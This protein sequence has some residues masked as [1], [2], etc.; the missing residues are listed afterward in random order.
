MARAL[1]DGR[2]PAS[3]G[4]RANG[5]GSSPATGTAAASARSSTTTH[6]ATGARCGAAGEAP[7][8]PDSKFASLSGTH[9][10]S[11]RRRIGMAASV[12]V[13]DLV[14]RRAVAAADMGEIA[15]TDRRLAVAAGDIQ[16]VARLAQAGKPA[17]ER[18]QQFLTLRDAGAPM[19][20]ARREI[21]VMQVVG[22][23]PA[24]DQD[25]QQFA[26]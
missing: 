16:H 4:L 18:A 9:T 2:R 7:S 8:V 20:G 14:A 26:E 3:A 6:G 25:A 23:D 11:A 13:F 24:F 12:E 21:G 19:R 17:M 5:S 1:R 15:R 22:L 10:S